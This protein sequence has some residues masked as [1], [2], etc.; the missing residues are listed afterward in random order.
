[1]EI[2]GSRALVTGATGGIGQAIA[3]ELHQRGAHVVLT[4][5][6]T[7]V[8]EKLA[9]ELGERA[10]VVATDLSSTAA[11]Q[12]LATGG[13]RVDILVANAAVP[14]SGTVDDYSPEEIDRAID[15]N[16]RAPMQLARALMP[17]MVE[18]GSGHFVFV[19]SISG[20]AALGGSAVYSATKFGV[21][22]FAFGL[23]EDLRATG[24]GVTTVFPG[25]IGDA[26]MF[27]ETGIKLP[28]GSGTRTAGDVAAAVIKGV[29]RNKAEIDV[30]SLPQRTGGWLWPLAPSFVAALTRR[31]GGDKLAEK[32]SEAQRAKR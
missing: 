6:R 3:R 24:V 31:A 12:D 20:K 18:R 23:R 9:G 28:A 32:M 10:D 14:G 21:R 27:A 8:L 26:G 15:V 16:L 13:G 25:F 7:E 11:A 22:G 29:E 2:E 19:A 4:G 17:G 1:M 30:A 5:R